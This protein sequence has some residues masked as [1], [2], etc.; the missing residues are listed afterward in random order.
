MVVRS[1]ARWIAVALIAAAV[2]GCSLAPTRVA[3]PRPEPSLPTGAPGLPDREPVLKVAVLTNVT[4]VELSTT[5]RFH[6]RPPG[7]ERIL[8]EFSAGTSLEFVAGPAGRVTISGSSARGLSGEGP[9]DLVPTGDGVVSVEGTRYR[10][11]LE[12][13]P[14]GRG[15]LTVINL[16]KME[17]YLRGVVPNEIGH[18]DPALLEAVKAQAVAARTYAMASRGQYAD[19]G[20][21]LLGT[22][23]DQLYTGVAGEDPASDFAV[24]ETRGLVAISHG[25]PIV[26]NYSSTCGGHTAARD[27]VWDKPPLS[28]LAGVSD[29][30]GPDGCYCSGSKYYRWRETWEGAEFLRIV[31][32]NLR[33]VTGAVIPP[34]AVLR[35]VRVEKRGPSGRVQSLLF[36]TSRGD[37]RAGGDR[38]RWIIERPGGSGPLWSILFEVKVR[39]AGGRVTEIVIDGRGWGHGVGMCQ[40]GAMERSRQGQKCEEILRHYYHGIRLERLY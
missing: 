14:N 22:V 26:T 35:D 36:R 10:G 25:Q 21:D 29:K 7:G 19:A 6:L 18:R 9:L 2:A 24:Q 4:S 15:G 17:D 3:P 33:E 30:G 13:A 31:R 28:Y 32:D 1:A 27:E 38:L 34:E 5:S 37:F 23:A 16:V 11:A 40:W 20:Y 39:R 12:I 8:Q